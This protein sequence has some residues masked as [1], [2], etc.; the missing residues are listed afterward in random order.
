MTWTPDVPAHISDLIPYQPG[1]P[2]E[3]TK[4]EYGL[5]RVVKLAS[6]ENPL[7]P[8]PR[9][10]E[11]V[12][13]A[14]HDLN[15]YPDGAHH[16]LKSALAKKNDMQLNEISV[17]NGSN[18]FIDLLTRV[19]VPK[20]CNLV[21]QEK[22]FIAYKV[23]AELQGCG[24]VQAPVDIDF[25][26]SAEGILATVNAKTRMVLLANP[27]N[28][29]GT[30]MGRDEVSGLATELNKRRILLVLDYAY[31]E[32]VTEKSIPDP[33]ELLKKHENVI[34]LKTFS[35][36][37]GLAGL[38]LGMLYARPEIVSTIER[39]REPFNVNSLALVAGVAA[40]E[41]EAFVKKARETNIAGLELLRAGLSK[42]DVKVHPF[43]A[44]KNGPSQGNFL[45]VD[46]K[47]PTVSGDRPLYPE[48]LKRGVIIRPVANYGL[49]NHFRISVGTKEEIGFFLQAMKEI[50][51]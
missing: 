32:Y 26:V 5:D 2:I 34:V 35:K 41:D 27:N 19:F 13:K 10:L 1:K 25:R 23:C 18:E 28:P 33:I 50:M 48:F 3:E 11:A 49:P 22:A 30:W 16:A 38:R 39:A 6:N 29:T 4:R 17:G 7:G 43:N 21:A 37:Y 8:S 31:W 36:I 14:L 45:L 9:A 12:E 46:F 51:S 20:D 44:F 40:L 24:Y 42:F 15:L 47:R